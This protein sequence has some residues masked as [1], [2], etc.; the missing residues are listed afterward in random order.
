MACGSRLIL[1][2]PPP[3]RFKKHLIFYRSL[4]VHENGYYQNFSPPTH[5]EVL[6]PHMFA[7]Y[8]TIKVLLPSGN[9]SVTQNNNS[10][11][12]SSPR[13]I[14]QFVSC[15]QSVSVYQVKM[16]CIVIFP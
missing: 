9:D 6:T 16:F 2:T 3:T 10:K 1:L 12:S 4:I 13:D 14:D 11:R 5:I 8:V 7:A 15:M